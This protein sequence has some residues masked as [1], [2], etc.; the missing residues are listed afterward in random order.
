MDHAPTV[1]A[2]Q[3]GDV[4][5]FVVLTR[6]YQN[7]AFGTALALVGDFQ[8]AE[9]VV[10]D[11]MVQAWTAL[12]RL[13][14]P[15]A[16]P[17][18]LRS[19]VR[20]QAFRV[21]RR[22]R[23]PTVALESAEDI[24]GDTPTPD[25]R[26]DERAA[27]RTA[28]VALAGLPAGLREPASLYFVHDCSQQDIATFLD[29]SVASV[30]NRIHAA[31]IQL[32]ERM[33]TMVS[34]NLRGRKLS[35]DF[36]NRIG[37]LAASDGRVVEALFDPQ[38]APELLTEMAISDQAQRGAVKV[39]VV[40]R[41]GA[42]RV[43]AIALSPIAGPAVGSTVLSSGRQSAEPVGLTEFGQIL[44][45]LCRA[46]PETPGPARLV[47]TGIKAIDLMC[48]LYAGAKVVVAGEAGAGASLVTEELTRRLS[49][50]AAPL[51]IIALIPLRRDAAADWSFAAQLEREGFGEGAAGAV[52]TFF[53]AS[54]DAAW[55]GERLALLS[56]ADVVIRL[57][58]AHMAA[59]VYPPID[60][61]K[62]RSRLLEA[63][64]LAAEHADIAGRVREAL[65][66]L[67]RADQGPSH[68]EDLARALKLQNFFTQPLGAARRYTGRP[69]VKVALAETIAVCRDILERHHDDIPAHAF[70]F[71]DGMAQIQADRD[72]S[73]S[74]GPVS[75]GAAEAR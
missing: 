18:W 9:D 32:K 59:Q 3:R 1:V 62:S 7:F 50:N 8:L 49:D 53:F 24:P 26:V 44:S 35:D 16:F 39:Q 48:P 60:V 13:D 17:G 72:R 25:A 69:G 12:P 74:F 54:E 34:D 15:S 51:S 55:T 43:R 67:W 31:R 38:A 61:L 73:L 75:I 27:A 10:Q 45:R 33:L 56:A 19:I 30:N 57:S 14:E 64:G 28:L 5:A 40:Q 29:L 46:A 37:R 68:D 21:L 52:E 47:E 20:R 58:S 41:P 36:A 4:A 63:G 23:L 42:G 11:A 22:R 71:S 65:A 66:R 70:F 2:A 6:R